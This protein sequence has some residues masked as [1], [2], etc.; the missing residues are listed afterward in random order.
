[1]KLEQFYQEF[2][3]QVYEEIINLNKESDNIQKLKLLFPTLLNF[4]ST[5]IYN[6]F[7]IIIKIISQFF[8]CFY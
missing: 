1:M 3:D 2:F 8:K 7:Q 4:I 5:I 6:N